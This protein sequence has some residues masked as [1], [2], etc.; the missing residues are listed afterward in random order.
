MRKT[1]HAEVWSPISKSQPRASHHRDAINRATARLHLSIKAKKK[2][3]E[4][5][6]NQKVKMS[7]LDYYRIEREP[8]ARQNQ[9]IL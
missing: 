4:A 9:N 2:L 8:K 1:V 6:E 5:K 7:L 3:I